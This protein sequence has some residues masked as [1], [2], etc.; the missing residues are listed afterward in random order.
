M[1]DVNEKNTEKVGD[2]VEVLDDHKLLEKQEI[3]D[4]GIYLH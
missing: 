3:P 1:E 2:I 4:P